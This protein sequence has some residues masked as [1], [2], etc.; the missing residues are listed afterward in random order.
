MVLRF[1]IRALFASIILSSYGFTQTVELN[2]SGINALNNSGI[3]SYIKTTGFQNAESLAK[4]ILKYYVDEGYYAATIETLIVQ[5][6]DE[7]LNIALVINEGEKFVSGSSRIL[8]SGIQNLSKLQDRSGKSIDLEFVRLEARE[9]LSE[10]INLGYPFAEVRVSPKIHLPDAPTLIDINYVID[11]GEQ[12]T[13]DSVLFEGIKLTKPKFLLNEMRF[14]GNL[15]YSWDGLN[16]RISALNRLGYI[17][18]ARQIGIR[19]VNNSTNALIV[20]LEELNANTVSGIIGYVPDKS[21]VAGGFFTG[22]IDIGF[23]NIFGSGRALNTSWEKVDR[24]TEEF[25]LRY[26]EPYPFGLPLKPELAYTQLIQDSS[27]IKRDLEGRLKIP[28]RFNLAVFGDATRVSVNT[29]TFGRDQYGL[30][31]YTSIVFT[32]GFIYD[33]RDFPLNPV[34]GLLYETNISQARRNDRNAKAING[35]RI[36]MRIEYYKRIT[37]GTVAAF[38]LNVLENKYDTGGVP[39]SELYR[40][41]G[42]TTLRGYREDQFRG[43]R[44][45]WINLEYRLITGKLSRIFVFCDGAII[46][47]RH[48]GGNIT[49]YSYGGG[50]RLSTAIGQIGIDYGLGEDDSFANGKVHVRLVGSF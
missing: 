24:Q 46:N 5:R 13:I 21:E 42:A 1:M 6:T 17:S 28:I 29:R 11:P 20:S 7:R 27:Y 22:L 32:G 3:Q 36:G 12:V 38:E 30:E 35:K 49:K 16:R 43:S 8:S 23:G 31:D 34:S 40:I 26:T 45:G 9:I 18:N 44:V 2:Y 10:L 25:H 19:R 15:K 50:I 39:F 33:D 41:G 37:S 47:G 14:K 48:S 4:S